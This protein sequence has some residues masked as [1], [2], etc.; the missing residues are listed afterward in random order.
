MPRPRDEAKRRELLG[1]VREY[2]ARHG[3]AE[4]S[5]RPLARELGTSDRMLLYYFGTKER[6]IA[7]ALSAEEQRP[8]FQIRRMLAE[9]GPPEDVAGLRRFL[10]E[11]WQRLNAPALREMR[12]LFLEVQVLSL[13]HS[14][15]Y[16]TVMRDVLGEWEELLVPILLGVGLPAE[17][18][19][20]EA[21]LLVDATFGLLIGS[22]ASQEWARADAAFQAFLDSLEPGW[23][24]V[25]QGSDVA[26]V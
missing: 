23:A 6:L 25:S 11:L 10:E 21:L 18:A 3:L 12:P 19:R 5:L 4:L 26:E 22:L 16:G 15:R 13:R 20:T 1:R 2:V 14:D 9:E 8:Q 7:E 17:R 24:A